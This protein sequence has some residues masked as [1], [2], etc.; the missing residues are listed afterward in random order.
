MEPKPNVIL[1]LLHLADSALPIGA[2]A[3]SFGLETLAE[4]GDLT[5]ETTEAFL[6][7]YLSEAGV[8]EASF[9]RRAFAHEDP[10]RL[11]DEFG[12]RRVARE[13]R[14]AALKMGRRFSQLVKAILPTPAIPET[15]YYP[16]AFGCAAATLNISEEDTVLAYLRQSIAGLVSA[17][18]RLMPLGQ[19]EASRMIWNLRLDILETALVSKQREVGCFTPLLESASARHGTLE[20]RLFIS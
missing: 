6:R 1:E 10:H 20:T 12:A 2:A 3:H 8:L 14:D 17:C 18:Q 9:V 16:I 19:V 13:S 11:C 4:E 7:D 5:P 15:V